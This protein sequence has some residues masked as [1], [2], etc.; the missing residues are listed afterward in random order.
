ME[1]LQKNIIEH[2]V[3]PFIMIENSA[4]ME[5]FDYIQTQATQER[6]TFSVILN[7]LTEINLKKI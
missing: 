6:E 1:F 2:A 3:I 7:L 4:Y 5:V